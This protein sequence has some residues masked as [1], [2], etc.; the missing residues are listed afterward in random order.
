MTRYWFMQFTTIPQTF[1]SKS[2]KLVK[3]MVRAMVCECKIHAVMLK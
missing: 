1:D 3:A 2:N